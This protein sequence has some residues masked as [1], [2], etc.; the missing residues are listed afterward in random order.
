MQNGDS[1]KEKFTW[2][3][4]ELN[5]RMDKCVIQK[6]PIRAPTTAQ[7]LSREDISFLKLPIRGQM[8]VDIIA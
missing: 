4:M 3:A 8:I 1:R 6:L 2:V 7:L 5:L